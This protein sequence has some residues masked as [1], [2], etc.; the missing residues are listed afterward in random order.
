MT[1]FEFA[2]DFVLLQ[3]DGYVNDPRD[4][5]GETKYGISKKA[6]PDLDIA[7]LT[8]TQAKEIYRKQ[9]WNAVQADEL[10][11]G[12]GLM[13]FDLAVNA[14]VHR[15]IILLQRACKVAEDGVLGPLTLEAAKHV[16]PMSLGAVR[17]EFYR[18]LPT[19]AIYGHGWIRRTNEAVMA[20]KKLQAVSP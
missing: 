5:G 2:V 12:V 4:P 3:E 19:Y 17:V 6:F 11:P 18:A 15:S 7:S 9:Y 8:V 1:P 20:A 10:P 14:G 16:D 13:V